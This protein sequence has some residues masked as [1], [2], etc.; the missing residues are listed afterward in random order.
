[1][2]QS[3]DSCRPAPSWRQPTSS[4]TTEAWAPRWPQPAYGVPQLLLPQI[5]DQFANAHAVPRARIGQALIGPRADG[6]VGD[7]LA[8]LHADL[9]TREAARAVAHSIADTPGPDHVAEE[10]ISLAARSPADG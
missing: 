6:A 3:I 2:S 7:A 4:F 10:L 9:D 1:M 8:T 5:G